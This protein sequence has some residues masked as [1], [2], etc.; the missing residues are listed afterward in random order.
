MALGLAAM[1][2]ALFPSS[3]SLRFEQPFSCT[4]GVDGK[5]PKVRRKKVR[6]FFSYAQCGQ[7]NTKVADFTSGNK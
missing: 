7:K 6:N 5:L 3:R 1:G 2:E 4:P